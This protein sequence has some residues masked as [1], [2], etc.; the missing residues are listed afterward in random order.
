MT[1]REAVFGSPWPE[2]A[3][4]APDAAQLSP[5]S[6]GAAAIESVPDAS[7]ARLVVAAPP[8][9]LERRY[10]LAHG[11][12]ALASG[13]EL[14]VLALK[15]KG[16]SRLRK[17]L[18][19][20]GC[21]VVETA[22]RHH[23]ICVVRRPETPVG[24]ADAIREG[25]PRLVETLR[26]WSQPGLFAWDRLDPGSALLLDPAPDFSGR[27]ADLGCGVGVLSR[28][29]LASPNVAAVTLIDLDRRAIE[30]A[31]RN[32]ADARADFLQFDLRAAVPEVKDLDFVI[33]N[34]P[35][36][37]GGGEDRYLGQAFIAT[38]AAMLKRGGVCR[39]VANIALPYEAILQQHFATVT[40]LARAKGYKVFEA[41]K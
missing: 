13:G 12:R 16:G 28:A 37:E 1:S 41:R 2:L 21:A 8:G 14:L 15:D 17:E 30:A 24:L 6:L 26:L 29:V 22:R 7:L 25:A 4:V 27:G 32:I 40:P 19:S 20:L 9:T 31:R 23:R 34:P 3:H 35:F 38:A 11:L 36:H 39:L 33:M 5:F 10:T 18:E